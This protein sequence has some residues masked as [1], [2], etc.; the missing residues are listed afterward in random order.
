MTPLREIST[1]TAACSQVDF[2]TSIANNYLKHTHNISFRITFLSFNVD[3]NLIPLSFVSFFI[4]MYVHL[5]F[6]VINVCPATFSRTLS[7]YVSNKKTCSRCC[8]QTLT[9]QQKPKKKSSTLE[10]PSGT[11]DHR[12]G[13]VQRKRRPQGRR[14]PAQTT[15]VHLLRRR[16]RRR[17]RVQSGP[18]PKRHR[19]APASRCHRRRRRR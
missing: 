15:G 12:T 11:V 5:L 6:S 7:I 1:F 9:S 18:V 10:N 17:Q 2:S 3:F 16:R 13:R 19:S 14:Q 4:F 8:R